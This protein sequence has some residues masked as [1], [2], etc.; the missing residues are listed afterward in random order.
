MIVNGI[1]LSGIHADGF[2]VLVVVMAR[3]SRG[4]AGVR[5]P[6]LRSGNSR[7]GWDSPSLTFFFFRKGERSLGRVTARVCLPGRSGVASSPTTCKHGTANRNV[8]AG[9]RYLLR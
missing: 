7:E 1:F 9:A 5:V 6:S 4:C 8:G 3:V 2:W